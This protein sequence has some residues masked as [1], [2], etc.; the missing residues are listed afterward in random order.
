MQCLSGWGYVNGLPKHDDISLY[1]TPGKMSEAISQTLNVAV[2]AMGCSMTE[3]ERLID[4][5]V[6]LMV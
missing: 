4:M 2:D 6:V 1:S 5:Q 3:H